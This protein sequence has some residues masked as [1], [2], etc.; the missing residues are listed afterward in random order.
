MM[1]R[2]GP[3]IVRGIREAV[4][5]LKRYGNIPS[6]GGRVYALKEGSYYRPRETLMMIEAPIQDIISLETIYLGVLSAETTKANDKH[7]VDLK[8]V[9]RNMAE[10]VRAA[11]ARFVS[12]FGARHWR[13]D[14]DASITY[15]AYL[16]GASS[17]STDAGAATFGQEGI[18][19]TPHVLENI[20][21]WKCGHANAVKEAMKAF[22]RIIDKKIPRIALVDYRN[23]EITDSL[24]T[25]M[26]L[27]GRLDGVRVDT[28]GENIA[29]GAIEIGCGSGFL[30]KYALSKLKGLKRM[31]FV[32]LN[33]HAIECAKDNVK[34]RRARFFAGDGLK[35]MKKK[36]FD[37]IICNP[38]YVPRPGSIEDNSYE[39]IGLLYHLL[40]F[41]QNY[42][43]PKGIIITN[44][45]SLAWKKVLRQKP[46]M[47]MELLESMEVPLKVNNI[48]NNEKW[49]EYLK[50][51]GL[52]KSYK[53]GYEYWQIINIVKLG[54]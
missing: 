6:N 32:D 10:V 8:Q 40:H 37:L 4:E 34:D 45:S 47:N 23:R 39:G 44:V 18:G 24:E 50:K 30:G 1:I 33:K 52:K 21:A 26:A 7:G 22:D 38:P 27:E 28:C 29:E 15:A 46:K 25:A 43:N 11:E 53:K 51:Q 5:I 31:W 9:R 3:G 35:F 20:F 48:L 17:A 41:G 42:L 36:K 13:F 19:T 2:K 12:Y 16:G 49:L 14:E 54:F